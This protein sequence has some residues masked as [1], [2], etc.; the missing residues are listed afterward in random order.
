M[1]TNTLFGIAFITVGAILLFL[2]KDYEIEQ[3][4]FDIPA[5]DITHDAR[6]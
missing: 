6:A 1:N 5:D 2:P 3:I 4:D